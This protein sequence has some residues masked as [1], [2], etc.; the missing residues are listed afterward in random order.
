MREMHS[1]LVRPSGFEFD[2]QK[3]PDKYKDCDLQKVSEIICTLPTSSAAGRKWEQDAKV[4]S[5][6]G[7][8]PAC[9][10]YRDSGRLLAGTFSLA[11]MKRSSMRRSARLW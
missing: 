2:S 11:S 7:S 6:S 3:I 5:I 4:V 1:D 8:L 10:R 9:R